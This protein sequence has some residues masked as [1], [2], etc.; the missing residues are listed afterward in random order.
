MVGTS[1]QPSVFIAVDLPD[2]LGPMM[3][4]NSPC[5]MSRSTPFK[6]WKAV[7]PSP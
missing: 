3:A 4:T 5:W 2:P 7:L 1:R 6:A